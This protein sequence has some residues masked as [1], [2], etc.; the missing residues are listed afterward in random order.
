MQAE[1]QLAIERRQVGVEMERLKLQ[2]AA[3]AYGMAQRGSTDGDRY[4]GWFGPTRGFS[5]RIAFSRSIGMNGSSA[6]T[7]RPG[8]FRLAQKTDIRRR[9]E[10]TQAPQPWSASFQFHWLHALLG[11]W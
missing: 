4:G 11:G 10:Y 2:E 8:D 5:P 1:K 7:N 9:Y 3:I 6:V